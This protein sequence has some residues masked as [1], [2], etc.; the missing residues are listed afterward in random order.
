MSL[1]I[2]VERIAAALLVDG[3][4]TVSKDS[5]EVDAYEFQK[6]VRDEQGHERTIMRLS[7]GQET[8]IPATGA[9]WVEPS[10]ETVFCPLTAILA[11]KYAA[12][13]KKKKN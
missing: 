4:H 12:G 1:A 2:D 7:V 11:V 9:H 10:G 8:L 5:F 13:K 3:W 6:L